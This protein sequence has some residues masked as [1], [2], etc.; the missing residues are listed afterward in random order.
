MRRTVCLVLAALVLAAPAAAG[1]RISGVDTSAYPEVRV[2]VV[3]PLG[4][5]VPGLTENG[6][7]VVGLSA[8]NLGRAKSVAL[9]ID[10]SQSMSGAPLADAAAAARAFVASKTAADRIEVMAFG[11]DA[12]ALTRFSNA[13]AD[14]DVALRTLTADPRSGTALW[15]AVVLAAQRLSREDTP[16]H[17]IILVSDGSDVSSTASLADAVAAAHHAHA[18]VYAIG[19]AGPA[20]DP[21][22]MRRLAT[23]TGGTYNEVTSTAQL[24]AIYASIGRTLAHSWEL[25]YPTAARPGDTVRLAATVAGQG[26]GARTVALDPLGAAS[27]ADPQPPTLLPRSVW[28]SRFAP[29]VVAALVGLLAL[30]AIGFFTAARSG[31]WLSARLAPHLGPTSASP[32][33]RRKRHDGHVLRSLFAAT[34]HAFENMKQFRALQQLIARADLP[35]RAAELLYVC[36]GCGLVLGVVVAVTGAPTLLILL[37]MAAGSAVP[38]LYVSFKARARIK[39]FDN[40]LP[41]LL[42]TIAASLKAG[43]SFRHAVQAVVDEGAEPASKDFRRVLN[44]TRL[45]R[46]MDDAL[47][48][49][50]A[51]VGS[52]NLTF[53]LTAV[54]IQRQIG[55]SLAGLFDT[56]AETVRQRQQFARKIRSLTA[57][58]RMS[59][60]TLIG[61]PFGVAL[62]LTAMNAGYMAPLWKTSTGHTLL[63]V[64]LGMM[65][66]GTVL[67][68]KIVSFK[69]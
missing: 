28:T 3:A 42:I 17:V 50:A 22:P 9:A 11:H 14:A 10:R 43:H 55:G 46:P 15:D 48:E 69:G 1:V 62:A 30:L 24:S 23:N 56:V 21:A 63:G 68:K 25:T 34:D 38:V 20:Y 47:A 29:L 49:M 2:T 33:H 41:D 40:Q 52:K 16:G 39:A 37:L 26:V 13:T 19:I 57:M 7:P 67:L 65:F 4:S 12:L 35:V 60:Y 6:V 44:E 66:V 5:A 18:S 58:G 45:G 59:A 51:R 53:V 61:L 31:K 32:K 27:L 54:T 36:L 8:V 64:A